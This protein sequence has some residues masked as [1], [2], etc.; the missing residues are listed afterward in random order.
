M[1][2][3]SLFNIVFESDTMDTLPDVIEKICQ[4]TIPEIQSIF[5]D[6]DQDEDGYDE[7]YGGG[8]ICDQIANALSSNFSLH[9]FDIVEGGQEGDDHAY[10]FVGRDGRAFEVDIPPN[11]YEYGGGYSWKKRKDV[12]FTINDFYINEVSYADVFE[13]NT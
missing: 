3:N 9:G 8:G 12:T 10:I 13:I 11:I 5:D 6:W 4:D 7:E 2:F 1:K